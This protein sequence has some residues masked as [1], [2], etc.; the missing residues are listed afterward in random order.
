MEARC[1]TDYLSQIRNKY[2]GLSIYSFGL[3]SVGQTK[4]LLLAS[5]TTS[6]PRTARARFVGGG[7]AGGRMR[8]VPEGGG[9]GGP[10][11]TGAGGQGD[12]WGQ[13][14]Q[15]TWSS[16]ARCCI[17]PHTRAGTWELCT[18]HVFTVG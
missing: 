6:S 7:G 2:C 8:N 11:S 17:S 4:L 12:Q 1:R 10:G 18:Q 15:D 5:M 3:N 16:T 9:A 13:G 14:D